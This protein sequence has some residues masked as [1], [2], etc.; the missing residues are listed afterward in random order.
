MYGV[1]N[2]VLDRSSLDHG[3][4]DEEI[5][6]LRSDN[7]RRRAQIEELEEGIHVRHV[8][9]ARAALARQIVSPSPRR[10]LYLAPP[11]GITLSR[12]DLTNQKVNCLHEAF[13]DQAIHDSESSTPGTPS[14]GAP[15]DLCIA[16]PS[17]SKTNSASAASIPPWATSA[18]SVP[19]RASLS[20]TPT[21][22]VSKPRPPRAS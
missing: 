2:A 3:L 14:A 13:F 15:S 6:S 18:G 10:P 12:P 5:G 1:L 9:Y 22:A 7:D 21:P 4:Q 20:Q 19:S 17:A 8:A 11:K 16:C